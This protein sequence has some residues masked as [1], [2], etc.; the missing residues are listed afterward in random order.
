MKKLKVNLNKK[1]KK[2]LILILIPIIFL[3]LL[4]TTFFLFKPRDIISVNITTNSAEIYLKSTLKPILNVGDAYEYSIS[5]EFIESKQIWVTNISIDNLQPDTDYSLSYKYTFLFQGKPV[6]FKTQKVLES[7]QTP[8]VETGN[9]TSSSFVLVDTSDRDLL[10]RTN[11]NSN[12]WAF[13]K[14]RINSQEYIIRDYLN[15]ETNSLNNKG[16]FNKAK[17]IV[18]S[19]TQ[20]VLAQEEDICDLPPYPWDPYDE[21]DAAGG[22]EAL[23]ED[24]LYD[25]KID[26]FYSEDPE[27]RIDVY[28]AE[29]ISRL[30]EYINIV[31]SMAEPGHN[32]QHGG[33]LVKLLT[34][35]E[36]IIDIQGELDCNVSRWSQRGYSS[37]Q[38]CFY[39]CTQMDGDGSGRRDSALDSEFYDIGT[40]SGVDILPHM[41]SQFLSGNYKGYSSAFF[42]GI[43]DIICESLKIGM[44]PLWVLTVWVHESNASDYGCYT[45]NPDSCT[46]DFGA[47]S[48]AGYYEKRFNSQLGYILF[49]GREAM[50]SYWG[51]N[52]NSPLT[53]W[54]WH[55]SSS[56][57]DSQFSSSFSPYLSP[58]YGTG[59]TS[60][61]P[62]FF[63]KNFHLYD[64]NLDELYIN[65]S[66]AYSYQCGDTSAVEMY[67]DTY[68]ICANPKLAK[69][70]TDLY[71]HD[72]LDQAYT[73]FIESMGGEVSGDFYLTESGCEDWGKSL[74]DNV[75]EYANK[76]GT[77]CTWD[78]QY[79]RCSG[80]IAYD[81]RSGAKGI[82]TY[83]S[84]RAGGSAGGGS[85][86]DW[87]DHWDD[88]DD[89]I[90]QTDGY[91]CGIVSK[92]NTQGDI[93]GDWEFD[94]DSY[95]GVCYDTWKVGE[96]RNNEIISEVIEL[97]NVP[98][99]NSCQKVFEGTCCLRS[100]TAQWYPKEYCSMPLSDLNQTQCKEYNNKYDSL[101]I[102]LEPGFNFVTWDLKHPFKKITTDNV[103]EIDSDIL[104]IASFKNGTWNKI[105]VKKGDKVAGESFE[106]LPNQ[107]YLFVVD[108]E[109]IINIQ[110]VTT[111]NTPNLNVQGWHLVSPMING[112]FKQY[113]QLKKYINDTSYNL[114]QT[115]NFDHSEQAFKYYISKDSYDEGYDRLDQ[116]HG[117]FIKIK[118][119]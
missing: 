104:M 80:V 75:S 37:Y 57:S 58:I 68:D 10:V 46:M 59:N 94:E 32:Y 16:L 31:S 48:I 111:K 43:P 50:E 86:S 107:P 62:V 6:T 19:L 76:D 83:G 116:N 92:G 89:P 53:F 9:L 115:A 29:D 60:G 8:S 20:N 49:A 36:T 30:I 63:R 45:N 51:S 4:I 95:P 41:Q 67:L 1:T 54:N 44:D 100:G 101:N 98:D 106:L 97:S 105:A 15:L 27:S 66:P 17:R 11:S 28:S 2:L 47:D 35:W 61:Y 109:N 119:D 26:A 56:Y 73:S 52:L 21:F 25:E 74:E 22:R 33:R 13:D 108:E 64:E 117:I 91:C 99:S 77:L 55:A 71:N 102:L 39:G 40:V 24:F 81:I 79:N 65:D 42:L 7:I 90:N 72:E 96:S 12:M 34:D 88:D 78:Q 84:A 118:Q 85:T 5:N 3:S 103:F 82:G 110:G 93:V 113:T 87:E 114:V 14:N 38:E 69:T 112:Q 70:R 18:A 23:L